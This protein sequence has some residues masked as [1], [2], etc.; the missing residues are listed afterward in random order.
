[1]TCHF[2]P[3]NFLAL[4]TLDGTGFEFGDKQSSFKRCRNAR[5]P[6]EN[7]ESL[8][9]RASKK[10]KF[11]VSEMSILQASGNWTSVKFFFFWRFFTR[12]FLSEIRQ[13]SEQP[14]LKTQKNRLN[15]RLCKPFGEKFFHRKLHLSMQTIL[16]IRTKPSPSK[17]KFIEKLSSLRII[18][19]LKSKF[20]NRSVKLW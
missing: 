7:F 6:E 2:V 12:H 10:L 3:F 19:N 15:F 18:I 8:K 1:M 16:C 4:D 5:L 11:S 17:R 9:V 13:F 20:H 14:Y